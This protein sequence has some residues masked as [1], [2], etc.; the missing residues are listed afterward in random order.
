[1]ANIVKDSELHR[2]VLSCIIYNDER[3]YLITKRAPTVKAFP[4][5]WHPPGGGMEM[6]DYISMPADEEGQWYS[7]LEEYDLIKGI[8]GEIKMVDGLLKK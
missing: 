5:K 6:S 1:M 8:A 2:I 7:V 3:K 4:N